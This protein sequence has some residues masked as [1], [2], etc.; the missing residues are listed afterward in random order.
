LERA[1]TGL[2]KLVANTLKR[3]PSGEGPLLAWPVA[4][5]S[6]VAKKTR[7]VAFEN[8]IL[9]V[10][11]PNVSWR[12]ELQTIAAQYLA[13]LNRYCSES[14]KRIEFVIVDDRSSERR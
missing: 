1:D 5:G 4:C 13:I 12:K 8:G 3:V 6:V 9:R 10:E 14:V 7:A 11:V 2:E